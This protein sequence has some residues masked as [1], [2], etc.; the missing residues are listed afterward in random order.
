MWI[1]ANVRRKKLLELFIFQLF[2]FMRGKPVTGRTVKLSKGLIEHY[3]ALLAIKIGDRRLQ[4]DMNQFTISRTAFNINTKLPYIP[5]SSL[6]GA[7]RTAYL[8]WLA[9]V[10]PSNERK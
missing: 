3:Q 7:L 2:K 10:K 1:G 5:G 9:K 6:K 4:N 8:N